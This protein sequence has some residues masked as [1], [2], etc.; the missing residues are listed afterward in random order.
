M[1]V[2]LLPVLTAIQVYF[3]FQNFEEENHRR[4]K[5]VLVITSVWRF[6]AL[7]AEVAKVL[8]R[9][10]LRAQMAAGVN[11]AGVWAGFQST[12]VSG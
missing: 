6:Q 5:R 9:I 4:L 3:L 10:L 12:D 7:N 11:I 8:S 1:K 2:Q